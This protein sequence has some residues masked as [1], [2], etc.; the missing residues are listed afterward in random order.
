[1]TFFYKRVCC[2]LSLLGRFRG[3]GRDGAIGRVREDVGDDIVEEGA[4]LLLLVL[5]LLLLILLRIDR[6]WHHGEEV[7][8]SKVNVCGCSVAGMMCAVAG[9]NV[10]EGHGESPGLS[11][12]SKQVRGAIDAVGEWYV[13]MGNIGQGVEGDVG[14]VVIG[15]ELGQVGE[16]DS[17][18]FG[19]GE[20]LEVLRRDG[21]GYGGTVC[22]SAVSIGTDK[23][24]NHALT[25]G[26]GLRGSITVFDTSRGDVREGGGSD[27]LVATT[28]HGSGSPAVGELLLLLLLL[29]VHV[30]GD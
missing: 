28:I 11:D 20:T 14:F 22:D 2:R 29:G 9:Y 27:I 7:E 13:C 4:L 3:Y 19:G 21:K 17:N 18:A 25:V 5:L 6:T 30:I 24:C 12:G 16:I 15:G 23:A 8:L 26:G 10:G 1:M